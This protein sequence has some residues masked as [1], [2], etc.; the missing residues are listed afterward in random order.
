MGLND[1]TLAELGS[2]TD[3]VTEPGENDT[4][5]GTQ[6]AIVDASSATPNATDVDVSPLVEMDTWVK[7]TVDGE[8]KL[9]R[10]QDVAN[11]ILAK[12]SIAAADVE[13]MLSKLNDTDFT[14]EF[15]ETV[16]RIA[17][18]T[19]VATNTNL[20]ETQ[21]FLEEKVR[22][23]RAMIE[24]R[25]MEILNDRFTALEAAY[26]SVSEMS[27]TVGTEM[28][29]LADLCKPA[30]EHSAASK[31][32]LAYYVRQEG[33]DEDGT[34]QQRK[35]LIDIRH[36]ALRSWSLGE[37][38]EVLLGIPKFAIDAFAEEHNKSFVSALMISK[39]LLTSLDRIGTKYDPMPYNLSSDG[40]NCDRPDYFHGMSYSHMVEFYSGGRFTYA[41]EAA[42][43]AVTIRYKQLVEWRAK[44]DQGM[45]QEEKTQLF[46]GVSGFIQDLVTLTDF[47][48]KVRKLYTVVQPLIKPFD[49][50]LTL[51]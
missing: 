28:K 13:A 8:E 42:Q 25:Y 5:V 9:D 39:K 50:I 2:P 33:K 12:E 16:D 37:F 21:R 1:D 22:Q 6:T 46:N 41:A 11:I 24:Q 19:A 20:Q 34:R 27:A 35:E 7:T 10:L 17:G 44:L 49:D 30:L 26:S 45:D 40:E 31:N 18:F 38:G 3:G 14:N 36:C 32:Y 29:A 51:Q 43:L 48:I 4:T 47:L 15:S 23:N